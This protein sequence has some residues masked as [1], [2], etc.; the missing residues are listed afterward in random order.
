MIETKAGI[1]NLEAIAETP[2]LDGLYIGPSDLSLALG[3]PPSVDPT[4]PKAVETIARIVATARKK[5]L[6]TGMFTGSPAQAARCAAQGVQ[7]CTI[8]NDARIL[9]TA[10]KDVVAAARNAAPAK[11]KNGGGYV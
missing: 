9:A 8:M 3:L 4:D 7:L 2:G 10:A 11:K 6:V 1:E 5:G